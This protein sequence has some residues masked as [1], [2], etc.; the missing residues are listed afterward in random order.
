MRRST[1]TEDYA[2][3]ITLHPDCQKR[4]VGTL[5]SPEGYRVVCEGCKCVFNC[6]TGN[7][8]DGEYI[9][10]IEKSAEEKK[11][12]AVARIQKKKLEDEA[13]QSQ[14]LKDKLGLSY[15]TKNG[16]GYCKLGGTIWKLSVE[17]LASI[18]DN[19]WTTTKTSVIKK[20]LDNKKIDTN[21][22]Q[23]LVRLDI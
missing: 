13:K 20:S 11:E 6:W 23:H 8:D 22:L 3:N 5:Y 21:Y 9:A 17:D 16:F 19:S 4:L 7:I 18:R 10:P 1:N 15:E 12:Y 14:D 2:P